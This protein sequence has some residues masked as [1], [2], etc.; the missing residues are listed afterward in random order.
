MGHATE[1]DVGQEA[2]FRGWVAEGKVSPVE[3]NDRS[4][5]I[6]IEAAKVDDPTDATR[7]AATLAGLKRS[8]RQTP[9]HNPLAQSADQ[10]T[11]GR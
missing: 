11:L 9:N 8:Q 7:R 2:A 5:A 1:F 3:P 10:F 6:D 4:N